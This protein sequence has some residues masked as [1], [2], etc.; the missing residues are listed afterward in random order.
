VF[1]DKGD[2]DKV[3]AEGWGPWHKLLFNNHLM[4]PKKFQQ[5]RW[6]HS[7]KKLK[8]SLPVQFYW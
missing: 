5:G 6:A 4:S 3:K 2:D 7:Q 8:R 1:I